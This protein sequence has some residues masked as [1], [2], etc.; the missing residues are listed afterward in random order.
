MLFCTHIYKSYDI[1]L[2]DK[3]SDILSK[4]CTKLDFAKTYCFGHNSCNFGLFLFKIDQN[5]R[6]FKGYYVG[7][8]LQLVSNGPVAS[9]QKQATATGGPVQK[10]PKQSGYVVA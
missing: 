7:N 8:R 1:L 5:V 9:F 3:A 10:G 6:I 4:S 2:V